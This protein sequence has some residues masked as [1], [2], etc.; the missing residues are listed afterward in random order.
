MPVK[1][2]ISKKKSIWPDCPFPMSPVV[3]DIADYALSK[4]LVVEKAVFDMWEYEPPR[5]GR[6]ERFYFDFYLTVSDPV[7]GKSHF[8]RNRL[9]LAGR[10]WF[11]EL[12]EAK[13]PVVSDLL[14]HVSVFGKKMFSGD[15]PVAEAKAKVDLFLEH[16][17]TFR[18]MN[19]FRR[20]FF[21]LKV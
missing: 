13:H 5:E 16:A 9:E 7:V 6:E 15:V 12:D 10:M 21:N 8:R 3:Q 18:R 2:E 20:D 17:E 1:F 19:T 4:G 11:S 14:A